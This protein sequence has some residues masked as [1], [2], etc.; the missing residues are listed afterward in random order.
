MLALK[1]RS[2]SFGWR[3]VFL[4]RWLPPTH[5]YNSADGA[6]GSLHQ[7]MS[8]GSEDMS[9]NRK[10]IWSSVLGW[11]C[12]EESQPRLK[13]QNKSN[14]PFYVLDR[15]K[16][17]ITDVE[18]MKGNH[19]ILCENKRESTRSQ[20][21]SSAAW[22][23]CLI[24]FLLDI[25]LPVWKWSDFPREKWTLMCLKGRIYNDWFWYLGWS[26]HSS[27]T[28]CLALSQLRR[29]QCHMPLPPLIHPTAEEWIQN[30]YFGQ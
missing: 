17:G 15:T 21:W 19:W 12:E 27:H 30:I 9:R 25:L 29:L 22:Q 28:I 13:E 24:R 14:S 10:G 20:V 4:T 11:S 2:V 6:P 1:P 18:L 5:N 16:S 8:C 7:E 26:I 23:G 3:A